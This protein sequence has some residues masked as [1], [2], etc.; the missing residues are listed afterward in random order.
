MPERPSRGQLCMIRGQAQ[1]AGMLLQA[2]EKLFEGQDIFIFLIMLPY[3][4]EGKIVQALG[5]ACRP[6]N[7]LIAI[8]LDPEMVLLDLH[9]VFDCVATYNSK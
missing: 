9:S 8:N 5:H 6:V 1:I 4:I 2:V 3:G 7:H